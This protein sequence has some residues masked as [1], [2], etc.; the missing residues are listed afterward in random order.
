MPGKKNKSETVA[1]VKSTLTTISRIGEDKSFTPEQKSSGFSQAD[2]AL[3]LADAFLAVGQ[4]ALSVA[5]VEEAAMALGTARTVGQA[6]KAVVNAGDLAYQA[7][8]DPKLQGAATAAAG[9]ATAVTGA[10]AVV[11]Q[12][13]GVGTDDVNVAKN[14]SAGATVV[15]TAVKAEN[16]GLGISEGLDGTAAVF[17]LGGAEEGSG[18]ALELKENYDATIDVLNV[19]AVEAAEKAYKW[20][21]PVKPETIRKLRREQEPAHEE[22]FVGFT[23]ELSERA[24]V[25]G[26]GAARLNKMLLGGTGLGVEPVKKPPITA[27][28]LKGIGI[29]LNTLD[30][31]EKRQ[32]V[33]IFKTACETAEYSKVGASPSPSSAYLIGALTKRSVGADS[34]GRI[35]SSDTVSKEVVASLKSPDF[36]N[37]ISRESFVAFNED[38]KGLCDPA[39]LLTE[40]ARVSVILR[41]RNQGEILPKAELDAIRERQENLMMAAKGAT[42]LLAAYRQGKKILKDAEKLA[43]LKEVNIPA[44]ISEDSYN[45]SHSLQAADRR[46]EVKGGSKDTDEAVDEQMG[47]IVNFLNTNDCDGSLGKAITKQLKT[48]NTNSP[49]MTQLVDGYNHSRKAFRE[50]WDLSGLGKGDNPKPDRGIAEAFYEKYLKSDAARALMISRFTSTSKSASKWGDPNQFP[51]AQ[52]AYLL[53]LLDPRDKKDQ[54]MIKA[55]QEALEQMRT[56]MR[57]T[58]DKLPKDED[59]NWARAHLDNATELESNMRRAGFADRGARK[60]S[61]AED[62]L[63]IANYTT[64]AGKALGLAAK[65]AALGADPSAP[66]LAAGAATLQL[67]GVGIGLVG[68]AHLPSSPG[69][70]EALYAPATMHEEAVTRK[71]EALSAITAALSQIIKCKYK[72]YNAGDSLGDLMSTRVGKDMADIVS[73]I[74]KIEVA[75]KTAQAALAVLGE[76]PEDVKGAREY[77]ERVKAIEKAFQSSSKSLVENIKAKLEAVEPYL[78]NAQKQ[79]RQSGHLQEAM[80]ADRRTSGYPAAP[81][82][83]AA[84]KNDPELDPVLNELT[85]ARE[86]LKKVQSDKGSS[87]FQAYYESMGRI[88]KLAEE[89]KQKM[90]ALELAAKVAAEKAAEAATAA[91]YAEKP[92]ERAALEVA[93]RA[94]EAAAKSAAKS[95]VEAANVLAGEILAA[96]QKLLIDS[97]IELRDTLKGMIIDAEWSNHAGSGSREILD[98]G[99]K[100]KVPSGIAAMIKALS[101]EVVGDGMTGNFFDKHHANIK[102]IQTLP[103]DEWMQF[104]IK[105]QLGQIRE[106]AD[107]RLLS[108]RDGNNPTTEFY[109]NIKDHLTDDMIADL[110]LELKIEDIKD[111]LEKALAIHEAIVS[112]RQAH[113]DLNPNRAHTV[114]A[115]PVAT[116][117]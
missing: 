101:G 58:A 33:Q 78:E 13:A 106:I 67:A 94:A 43:I 16:K 109:K 82:P 99:Q 114:D 41:G 75:L 35:L 45:H 30:M 21:P 40:V 15:S 54:P 93:A 25:G 6:V 97:R 111:P 1:V 96:K 77:S 29:G 57:D 65:A 19:S 10:A 47:L 107:E 62:I 91:V 61:T 44:V 85:A 69:A 102:K 98:N 5:G 31:D 3:G 27:L 46:S 55:Y 112:I 64:R 14:V 28:D 26:L 17:H 12:V 116:M 20:L 23:R 24:K 50:G 4:T 104:R 89:E 90:I 80:A 70:G 87:A 11:M 115:K 76:P 42:A 39:K 38:I 92:A 100:R 32:L 88:A 110:E 86:A 105:V 71:R 51:M 72:I 22:Q 37:S 95:A 60:E 66:F 108:K 48:E 113:D 117:G 103:V 36:P 2:K 84:P 83:S 9:V 49:L 56:V 59:G 81:V 8:L 73:N 53:G 7:S 74:E 63:D 68:K 18:E 52:V 79:N 34:L